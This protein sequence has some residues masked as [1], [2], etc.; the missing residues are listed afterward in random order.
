MKKLIL[1]AFLFLNEPHYCTA[2]G[3]IKGE[4]EV[5]TVSEEISKYFD[6][7]EVS[8]NLEVEIFSGSKNSYKLSTNENL[9]EAV[10]IT[11]EGNTLKIRTNR[12]I[13]QSKKLEIELQ[14]KKLK[15]LQLKDQAKLYSKGTLEVQD[16]TIDANNS[17][18]FD[19]EIKASGNLELIMYKNSGGKLEVQGKHT[20]I[21]MYDRTDLKAETETENLE[22]SMEN[23]AEIQLNGKTDHAEYHLENSAGLKARKMKC[24]TARIFSRNK[25]DNYVYASKKL[26]VTAEGKSKVYVYGHPD[27]ELKGL[28][29]SSQIIKK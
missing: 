1:L 15:H 27:I 10:E 4:G 23:S 22:V 17:S 29:N 9:I 21:E 3:K 5:V 24:R 16:L 26:E 19:L 6:K 20:A 11:V 14:V 25:S 28:T 13:T 12:K 18:K 7:I 8:D 2:Q